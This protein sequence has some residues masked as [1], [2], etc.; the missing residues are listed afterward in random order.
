MKTSPGNRL[1]VALV[2][3]CGKGLGAEVCHQLASNGV[4]V[5]AT[6]R[7]LKSA[8][9]GRSLIDSPAI[10]HEQM[11]VLRDDEVSDVVARTLSRFGSIDILVNNAGVY[12]DREPLHGAEMKPMRLLEQTLA[13]NLVGAARVMHAVLPSMIDRK[14]GTIV[15]VSSGMGRIVELAGDAIYYRTSKSALTALTRC[16]SQRVAAQGITVNAVCPGWV[17]TAMGGQ[18]AVRSVE[19]GAAG[20]VSAALNPKKNGVLLRDSEDFGW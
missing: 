5:V 8:R 15:N 14:S 18:D 11:D 6:Y 19:I 16:I 9:D 3:G 20:I 4:V 2:T 1:R 12:L 13:V 10:H 7:N 17:R